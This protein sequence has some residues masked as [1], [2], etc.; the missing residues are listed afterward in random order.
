MMDFSRIVP[1][2]EV[3]QL[4]CTAAMTG[5]IWFVQ[6]V[7]YPSFRWIAPEHWAAFHRRHTSLTGVIV[8]PF[9]LGELMAA[10]GLFLVAPAWRE[11]V[12]AW[13]ALS[14][15][16]LI[17]LST[18]VLQIPRHHRLEQRFDGRVLKSLVAT[19]WIRTVGW[20]VRLVCLVQ[21]STF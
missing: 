19:N 13:L 8:A 21:I 4:S 20:T 3:L 6:W 12:T 7:H 11:G 14:M 17:W 5:I 16:A 2:L 9:M 10:I 1:S 15:L 18:I